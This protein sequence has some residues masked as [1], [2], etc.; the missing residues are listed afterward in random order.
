M[1]LRRV[2]RRLSQAVLVLAVVSVLTFVLADLAPGDVLA[3]AHLDRRLSPAAVASM[4]ERLGLDR[5]LHERYLLWVRSVGR[6]EMGRSLVYDAPVW[7]LVRPRVGRT[8]LLSATA[9][10][11]AWA[12][13]LLLGLAA[14][15]RPRGVADR[16]LTAVSTT[17]IAVP[18]VVLLLACLLF[19]AR[20]GFFPTGGMTSARLL[21]PSWLAHAADVARHLALPAAALA[22]SLV[23]VL[24][25]HVRG[26]LLEVQAQPFVR[27]V[28]AHGI[29]E[30]RI[31]LRHILP[32]A[33]NPLV[34]LFGAT[35][36]TLL[37]VS[38]LTE[39]VFGWP[40]LGPL[41]LEAILARDVPL[42]LGP[43]L[44]SGALLL[45]GNLLA[46]LLLMVVD[47]RVRES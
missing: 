36:G 18:D 25:R 35:I 26:A 5:P 34:T 30:R 14:A 22:L 29:S 19:A 23:P 31:L 37:S 20:S 1:M 21:D 44:I 24:V 10:L 45:A 28:R 2:G 4:R 3:D 12:T 38:I 16:A 7:T 39:V 27:A 41:L 46:D 40:G 43:V 17:L 9:A 8:L 42:V 11:L 33:A 13:A 47:P 15:A 6:G 32:A